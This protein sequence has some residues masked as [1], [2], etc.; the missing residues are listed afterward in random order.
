[1]ITGA[2]DIIDEKIPPLWSDPNV[3]IQTDIDRD[4]SFVTLTP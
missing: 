4:G 2:D 1:M 3:A